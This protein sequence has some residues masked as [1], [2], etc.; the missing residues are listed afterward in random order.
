MERLYVLLG[1]ALDRHEPH[2]GPSDRLADCVGIVAV[3]LLA[4]TIWRDEVWAHQPRR[5]AELLD[6]A[7]PVMSAS[8]SLHTD[9][10]WF[11]SRQERQQLLAGELLRST[12]A[13]LKSTPWIRKMLFAKS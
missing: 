8:T 12:T 10:T 1:C 7:R 9:Q 3:I 13:P 11:Q 6:L 2:R 5:V 4:F